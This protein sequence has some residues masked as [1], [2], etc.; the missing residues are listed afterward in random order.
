MNK[1]LKASSWGGDVRLL[2]AT[3]GAFPS[4]ELRETRGNWSIEGNRGF[5]PLILQNQSRM[6]LGQ[7]KRSSKEGV[8]DAKFLFPYLGPSDD[9]SIRF[10][11]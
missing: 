6:S 3:L 5:F 9:L 7:V 2:Q 8:K 10:I 11:L 4:S 1:S